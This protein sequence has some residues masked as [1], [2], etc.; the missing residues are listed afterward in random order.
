[1]SGIRFPEKFPYEEKFS[2]ETI[3]NDKKM[4]TE[5]YNVCLK[6]VDNLAEH[7]RLLQGR[8]GEW[9]RPDLF[10]ERFVPSTY[11]FKK[12]KFSDITWNGYVPLQT[13]LFPSAD[14]EII[15]DSNAPEH[16]YVHDF[17]LAKLNRDSQRKDVMLKAYSRFLKNRGCDAKEI[18][19]K[20]NTL[21]S[22]REYQLVDAV[23]KAAA[24]ETIASFFMKEYSRMFL[25]LYRRYREDLARIEWQYCFDTFYR[26]QNA[27][28]KLFKKLN[29]NSEDAKIVYDLSKTA[30]QDIIMWRAP[31]LIRLAEFY[32]YHNNINFSTDK[33]FGVFRKKTSGLYLYMF[34]SLSIMACFGE[35][36]PRLTLYFLRFVSHLYRY[37]FGYGE[38]G[39]VLLPYF[40]DIPKDEKNLSLEEIIQKH[41]IYPKQNFSKILPE[42]IGC[43]E[44]EIEVFKF[45]KRRYSE[46]P[47]TI[48]ARKSL[49]DYGDKYGLLE[50][51]DAEEDVLHFAGTMPEEDYRPFQEHLFRRLPDC[52]E[53]N[54][55][56]LEKTLLYSFFLGRNLLFLYEIKGE[57][58]VFKKA[59]MARSFI[60]S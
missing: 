25:E 57:E 56:S 16:Y 41:N 24:E 37:F 51:Y 1:M 33:E 11:D 59:E 3:A 60:G 47:N 13:Y 55:E 27:P 30:P 31:V 48:I 23:A 39:T 15:G 12:L 54:S 35:K 32:A 2:P 17:A 44:E 58:F 29:L 46:L 7:F 20:L 10:S 42:K 38:V 40:T 50:L 8:E 5:F 14:P 18:L 21:E 43:L 36:N 52:L 22:M 34:E 26:M 4:W 6:A 45:L 9:R 49:P 53:W 19:S 28:F